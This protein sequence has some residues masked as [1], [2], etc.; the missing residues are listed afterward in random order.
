MNT[1]LKHTFANGIEATLPSSWYT[2]Q[3]VFDLEREHIFMR[4]WLCVGRAED[5]AGPGDHRVLDV[6]G[7]SVILLRNTEGELRA[8]YNVCRHRGSRLCAHAA[9]A[10]SPLRGGV[11]RKTITCPYHA[12]TYDLDGKLLRAP[13]MPAS[14]QA[15]SGFDPSGI[16]LHP[17]GVETWG[18]F[19][20]INM[21]PHEAPDFKTSIAPFGERWNRYGLEDLRVAHTIRYEAKANLKIL[22]ENYNE[23]YHCGPVHPE[24]CRIVPAFREGGGSNLEWE[25]GIPH[26]EGAVTFTASGTSNRR[27]F[28]G[29]NE[30]E[31]TR[32]FGDL[33]FPNLFLSLSCDHVAAFVLKALGPAHCEIDCHFLFETH[34]MEKPGFDPSDAVDFW[35]VI[36]EQDWAICARVQQGVSSRVHEVGMCSPMEDWTLDIRQYVTERIGQHITE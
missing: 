21:T 13:H 17:V 3:A 26:R 25:D 36:N 29:L 7:E 10:D 1:R 5:L 33:I 11:G 24:L 4:E 35:H 18:G 2:R 28:P 22:C 12:W 27:P 23:C 6:M 9:D 15:E 8:F 31:Q 32:H 30:A 34:E 14:E 19:V 16:R 20:F